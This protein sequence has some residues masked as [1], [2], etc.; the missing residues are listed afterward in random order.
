MPEVAHTATERPTQQLTATKSPVSGSTATPTPAT[1]RTPA[2]AT[3]DWKSWPVLPTVSAEMQ[4][5]YRLGLEKGN[6]PHAFSVLG[7]CQS[8]PEAFLGPYDSDPSTVAA[9]PDYL[10]ET[11][12]NFS[13]SFDRYSPTVKD[14]TTAGALLWGE[15]NDNKE[16][17]CQPGETPLDCE[18]R[19]HR[20]SIVIIHIG[21]H[22][23]TRNYRY[24]TIIVEKI[25]EHGAVPVLATKADNRELDERVNQDI[26]DLAQ[27]FDLPIW[28]FWA[29]MQH[30]P[31]D[32][33]YLNSTWELTDE[34]K[35]IHRLSALEALDAVWRAVR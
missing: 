6:D 25:I 9:L 30:M 13:G 28:N 8:L 22:W 19:V 16:K 26:A 11:V 17:Q 27:E 10:Q 7:D 3:A 33:I 20:P 32:G 5:V 31:N 24:L 1:S 2:A 23:E 14:G 15:W 4:D 35:E 29:T 21:T 12:D 18:L 34:A